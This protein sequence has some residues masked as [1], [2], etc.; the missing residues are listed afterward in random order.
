MR[1][2][3]WSRRWK[4]D[5]REGISRKEY[6]FARFKS[7]RYL[8]RRYFI[9]RRRS[10]SIIAATS[11][12]HG[13]RNRWPGLSGRP[14]KVQSGKAEHAAETRGG[15]KRV[16]METFFYIMVD[17]LWARKERIQARPRRSSTC[18]QCKRRPTKARQASAYLELVK[19][20]LAFQGV[21]R[22]TG[23]I[24]TKVRV[25]VPL[26][27]PYA[28]LLLRW[29]KRDQ[30]GVYCECIRGFSPLSNAR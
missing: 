3:D 5:G 21:A 11:I 17:R 30:A 16:W 20:I 2:P 10:R 27:S 24:R 15:L 18:L 8:A 28:V 6:S 29:L 14:I 19:I 26:F 22:R 23:S 7:R 25:R 13:E 9:A 1:S 12:E 4:R